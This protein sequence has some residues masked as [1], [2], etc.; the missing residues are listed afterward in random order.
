MDTLIQVINLVNMNDMAISLD[1]K[2]AYLHIPMHPNNRKY[3]RFHVQG[4]VYQSK[5]CVSVQLK[6][7]E[8]L[9]I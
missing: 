6:L 9:Q 1:L 4:K 7:K 2:D 5:Q 3:H 8:Y